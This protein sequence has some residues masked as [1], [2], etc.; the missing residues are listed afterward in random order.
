MSD[1]NVLVTAAGG[2]TGRA[3]VDALLRNRTVVRGL[4]RRADQARL[5]D[6]LG[7]EGHVGDLEDH[8]SLADACRGQDVVVHIGPPM[9]PKEVA[10]TEGV[11]A[12][13]K[14]ADVQHLV[15]YSVMHPLRQE[16]F[17]HRQKLQAETRIVGCELPYTIV[18][19]IRYMQHLEAIWPT[20]IKDGT[21]AMPFNT[22]VRFNVVDLLDVAEAVATIVSSSSQH[23][24]ATYELAGAEALSQDA[25]ASILSA[26]L[27]RPVVAGM[28]KP[29]AARRSAEAR[30]LSEERVVNM[31]DMNAHYDRHGFLG[32]ANVLRWLLGREPNTFRNYVRRLRDRA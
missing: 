32:N 2:R 20:V 28:I 25:M 19:P 14:T 9:H 1:I 24:Y 18:Q 30:G 8:Q 29:D 23:R 6:S 17:H 12:A 22:H 21:H 27:G 4:V 7:A 16:V 11:I 3:I 10:M 5:L 31:L 26:E 13:A 15:Y